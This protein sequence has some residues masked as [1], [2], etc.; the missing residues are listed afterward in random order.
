M[1][2]IPPHNSAAEVPSQAARLKDRHVSM[3]SIGGV[4]GASLF[5]GS[6]TAIAT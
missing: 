1:S 3:I 6:S 4:I 5:V 2:R